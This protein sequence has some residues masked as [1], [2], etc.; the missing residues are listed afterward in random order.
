M[1]F[2]KRKKK[3]EPT[4]KLVKLPFFN[5]GKQY[6]CEITSPVSI[7]TYRLK[8]VFNRKFIGNKKALKLDSNA[9]SELHLDISF[10]IKSI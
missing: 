3:Q 7:E 2:R 5:N 4:I 8:E 9:F 10:E 6:V 1:Y